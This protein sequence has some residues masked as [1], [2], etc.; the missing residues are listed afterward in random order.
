MEGISADIDGDISEL[1]LDVTKQA[2]EVRC[3]DMKSIEKL[4][5]LGVQNVSLCNDIL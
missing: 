3:R 2:S 4:R 5:L 1:A